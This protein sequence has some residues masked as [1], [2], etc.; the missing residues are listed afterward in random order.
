VRVISGGSSGRDMGEFDVDTVDDLKAAFAKK[1]AKYQVD[2][3]RFT[4]RPTPAAK[5]VSLRDGLRLSD[6]PHGGTLIF[7]DLG[8]Q[9]GWT[10]V[11]VVE[12]AG[13]LCA[14]ALLY[15]LRHTIYGGVVPAG[16]TAEWV[17]RLGVGCWIAH[18]AKREL[19]TLFVHRF[20]KGTMPIAN[21]FKNSAYYWGFAVMVGYYLIHPK[22]TPPTNPYQVYGGLA[23]FV[24]A[25]LLNLQCHVALRNLRPAGTKERRI[26][27]GGLFEL[28]SCPNYTFEVLAWVGFTIMTQVLGAALFTVVGLVQMTVWA[29]GKHR[30]YRKEFDGKDGRPAYPRGRKSIIPFI[31]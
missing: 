12:Y 17:Q 15:L 9:V 25:E 27:R 29:L 10:T 2:R 30:N 6:V 31:I 24:V 1:H 4:Y 26:P 14:M 8:P 11:F 21:I 20:S 3:Q 7:K 13:P 23:L 19:E 22:Y 16:S 18:Y 5:P 28:V